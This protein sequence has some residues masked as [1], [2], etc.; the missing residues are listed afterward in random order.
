MARNMRMHHPSATLLAW[1]AASFG[2]AR[3]Q[4]NSTEPPALFA[5]RLLGCDASTTFCHNDDQCAR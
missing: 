1:L 4:P 3:A 2:A 5:A